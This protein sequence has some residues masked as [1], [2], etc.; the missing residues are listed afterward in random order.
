MY[1]WDRSHS[2]FSR[3]TYVASAAMPSG[4]TPK[5]KTAEYSGKKQGIAL[6]LWFPSKTELWQW[7][8]LQRGC[9][10]PNVN[11]SYE[12]YLACKHLGFVLHAFRVLLPLVPEVRKDLQ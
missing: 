2:P 4:A 1:P 3:T 9:L 5:G 12:A 7:T 8:G 11:A 10:L 6:S